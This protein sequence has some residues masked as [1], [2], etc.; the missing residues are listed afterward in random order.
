MRNTNAVT[1][2]GIL[3]ILL[4]LCVTGFSL[5]AD[6][7]GE[8][9]EFASLHGER[10]ELY[11]RGVYRQDSVSFAVQ[12]LGQDIVTLVVGVPMLA[13]G[14][15]LYRKGK[16]SG[17]LLTS[18]TFYYFA[19]SYLLYCMG[20]FFNELFLLYVALFSLS[21]AGLILSVAGISTGEIAAA[22]SESFPRRLVGFFCLL[23]GLMLITLWGARL[24]P[25]FLEGT[26]PPG[27][28]HYTTL[29][30]QA[31]D[32]GIVVPTALTAGI[33]LLRR[34]PAGYVL[35]P[36]LIIKGFTLSLALCAMILMQSRAGVEMNP[37]ETI[38]FIVVTVGC[39]I[40]LWVTLRAVRENK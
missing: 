19:Y 38:P 6:Y 20:V 2:V 4:G 26:P 13:I 28:E 37:V 35:A 7:P 10:V 34:R 16:V 27:Q 14:I 24:A 22:F 21:T 36:I 32:L 40:L 18:G 30:V 9:D 29:I 8:I 1:V 3:V 39:V 33:L 12:G 5:I 23:V 11:G 15:V 17:F 25:A 31:A